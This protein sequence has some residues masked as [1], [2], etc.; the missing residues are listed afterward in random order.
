MPCVMFVVGAPGVGKTAALRS[1]LD[2]FNTALTLR[3]KWTLSNDVALVGHYGTGTFDGGDTVG[4]NQAAQALDY[5][6]EHIYPD[7]CVQLSV[8]DGDR[9]STSNCWRR[10][11]AEIPHDQIKCVYLTCSDQALQD[12]RSARNNKQNPSWMKG[13][14]TKAFNFSRHFDNDQLIEI[15]TTGLS[16]EQVSERI[17]E[18]GGIA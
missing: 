12:R 4:Y 13:R 17:R 16:V 7:P 2:P 15:D 11:T 14:A 3:P 9:F 18:A 8:L 5:W 6:L 10:V 1:L